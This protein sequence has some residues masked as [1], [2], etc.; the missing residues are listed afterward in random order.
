[1]SIL[2]LVPAVCVAVVVSLLIA[3]QR[4]ASRIDPMHELVDMI[5]LPPPDDELESSAA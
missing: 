2:L 3:D 5:E 4:E 1:M